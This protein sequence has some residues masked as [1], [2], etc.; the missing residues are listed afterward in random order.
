MP[1]KIEMD[2][3]KSCF[4]CMFPHI[5]AHYR[6]DMWGKAFRLCPFLEEYVDGCIQKRHPRCPLKEIE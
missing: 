1:V 3:P 6:K 4:E 5:E 2:M